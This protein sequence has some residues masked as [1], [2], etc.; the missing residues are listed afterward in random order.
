MVPGTRWDEDVK[1]SL[2][3]N[4]WRACQIVYLHEAS[5]LPFA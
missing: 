3:A 4:A 2:I 1:H 5:A